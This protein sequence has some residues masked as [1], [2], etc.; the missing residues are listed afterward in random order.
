MQQNENG[1]D[2]GLHLVVINAASGKV[3]N[4]RLFDT[5]TSSTALDE[6]IKFDVNKDDIVVAACNGD[7]A[8]KL[9]ENGREFFE[10]MG[11]KQI[12][13][14]KAN[15]SY[16]FIG[17][18]GSPSNGSEERH[19][20]GDVSVKQL[21]KVLNVKNGYKFVES[22]EDDTSK[23]ADTSNVSIIIQASSA[24]FSAGNYAKV[25]VNDKPVSFEDNENGTD[26]GLHVAVISPADGQVSQARVFD[27]YKGS[28]DLEDF[29]AFDIEEGDIV[30][31]AA[32]DDIATNISEKA[33]DFFKKMGSAEIGNVTFRQGFVFI[34][35]N[36]QSGGVEKRSSDKEEATVKQVM[37][38]G[39][40]KPYDNPDVNMGGDI[41][42]EPDAMD[43]DD[44]EP[45]MNGKEDP[46][47]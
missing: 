43:V 35:T 39:E 26:R 1:N 40:E 24:G 28:M 22:E 36:G 37:V 19:E 6:F 30:V 13:K 5:G 45:T 10:F 15:H 8:K 17:V 33:K 12:W 9:S 3:E 31:A 32:K 18:K 25:L 44:D 42:S 29:I 7:C 46:W 20:S 4:A 11:S 41:D 16:A 34:G 23:K 14:L 38:L 2:N 21:T 27:T 47:G